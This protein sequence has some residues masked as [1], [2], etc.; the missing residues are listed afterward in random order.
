MQAVLDYINSI[1]GPVVAALILL[2][3]TATTVLIARLFRYV[4]Q[5]TGRQPDANDVISQAVAGDSTLLFSLTSAHRSQRLQALRHARD[6][7]S[8]NTN[9]PDLVRSE[10]FRQIRNQLQSAASGLRVLEVIATVAPL[11]GL[12]GTVLGMIEAFRAMEAAG[13]QVD[14]S[15]LSGG[16][17]QALLTTA[18]G[19]GVAIPVSMLHSLGERRHEKLAVTL[20]SDAEQLLQLNLS[21][22]AHATAPLKAVT[23]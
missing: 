10:I 3:F 12:F 14:P 8:S 22:R 11:L 6:Y 18:V 15:V 1:G 7:L 16:I 19:L 13:A 21:E 9:R 23:A 5:N 4:I 2:S 20:Q 17:W